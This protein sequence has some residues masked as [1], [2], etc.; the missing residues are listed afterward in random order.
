M[1]RERREIP[2]LAARM[3]GEVVLTYP[4]FD[5]AAGLGQIPLFF[6]G[7]ILVP[8]RPDCCAARRSRRASQRQARDGV[9]REDARTQLPH[10]GEPRPFTA[11][12]ARPWH[13]S[14]WG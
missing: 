5:S 12:R 11:A 14:G 13:R 7:I 1:L 6:A 9:G 10:T 4:T 3:S 8:L 2:T